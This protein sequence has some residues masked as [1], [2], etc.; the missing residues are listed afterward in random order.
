MAYFPLE[1]L[2]FSV[3][4]NLVRE[5]YKS[6]ILGFPPWDTSTD[7]FVFVRISLIL[8]WWEAAHA[9]G[10]GKDTTDC[11]SRILDSN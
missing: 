9:E 10:S 6:V 7:L 3:L 11:V 8:P 4:D 5:R 1:L 2:K